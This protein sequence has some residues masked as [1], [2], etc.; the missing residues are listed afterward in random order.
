MF[1]Y[2]NNVW[3]PMRIRSFDKQTPNGPNVI[4]DNIVDILNKL[5]VEDISN[6]GKGVKIRDLFKKETKAARKVRLKKQNQIKE[7]KREDG[8]IP[9]LIIILR[10]RI[11]KKNSKGK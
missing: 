11:K 7:M 3:I 10:N 5:S 4:E 9:K 1:D 8:V 2:N 6:L